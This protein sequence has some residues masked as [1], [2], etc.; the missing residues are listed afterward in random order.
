MQAAAD[1]EAYAAD[2]DGAYLVMPSAL[3][4]CLRPTLWGFALWGRPSEAE[5]KKLVPV[6]AL[7]LA[8]GV[9]PH[10]SLI[11]VRRPTSLEEALAQ[12]RH[13]ARQGLFVGPSSGAYVA[14][15]LERARSGDHAIVVTLLNDTGERYSS[16]GMWSR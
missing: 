12:C 15:A 4:F 9:A 8:A 16:T 2:P 3:A 5:L 10:A 6:L 14:A 1:L 7:E 11:D 13:L